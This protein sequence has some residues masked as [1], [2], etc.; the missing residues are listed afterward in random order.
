MVC[1]END[2]SINV[3][4]PVLMIPQ[5]AGKNLKDLLDQGARGKYL[6]IIL[7]TSVDFVIFLITYTLLQ[8]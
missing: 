6:L 1:N 3:T 8:W 7:H 5:S 4:I 2:T